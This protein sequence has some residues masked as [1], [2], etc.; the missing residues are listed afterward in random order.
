MRPFR[1]PGEQ[2]QTQGYGGMAFFEV[3]PAADEQAGAEQ[4]RDAHQAGARSLYNDPK[5]AP[6]D[7]AKTLGVS[8]ATLYRFVGPSAAAPP[9]AER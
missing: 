6:P 2:H 8:L 4:G 9:S 3:V 7:I 1:A 5:N